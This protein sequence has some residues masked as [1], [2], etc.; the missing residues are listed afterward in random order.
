MNLPFLSQLLQF[1]IG[2]AILILL[3][4]FGHFIV[5]RLLNV[6]VEEFGIGFP[7]R[8]VKLFEARGTEFTLNWIPLGGFVRPKGEN[9]P[10]VEGGLAAASP[11]VR[12]AVMFAGPIM[13]LLIGLVLAVLFM[14]SLGAPITSQVEVKGVSPQSPAA[15]VGLQQGDVIEQI[16]GQKISSI[17]KLQ[18]VISSNL[19]KPINLTY[20]SPNGQTQT[21]TLT[22]RSSPPQGQGAIGVEIGNPSKPISF[23]Q[24]IPAGAQLAYDNVKGIVMLP[25]QMIQGTATPQEGRLVGYKGMFEI[26]T[27]LREPLYFFMA[28]SISLGILNLL[29]IPAL[30]GGRILLTLPEILIR[31]RIPAQY[32]NMIHLVGFTLLL[33]LLIYINLQDFINPLQLPK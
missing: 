7:P 19:D 15:Q 22:P 25:V 12:L 24:A 28:I 18:E 2:L 17:N 9:D 11:W 13:N 6:E 33:L 32:E 21:V 8:M 3:H 23:L 26:Y 5:S 14:Y 10:E 27:H 4:E 31:R 29:P 16:N 1:I 20:Q 30:D